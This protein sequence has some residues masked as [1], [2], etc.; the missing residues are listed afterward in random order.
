M[1]RVNDDD[2]EEEEDGMLR[3]IHQGEKSASA[4][5]IP[6]GEKSFP[7]H[8]YSL[9]R[10]RW[11]EDS[12]QTRP[13]GKHIFTYIKGEKEKAFGLD[14]LLHFTC[15]LFFFPASIPESKQSKENPQNYTPSLV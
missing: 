2:D 7:Q 11:R 5:V 1:T 8:L 3:S 15:K 12:P 6:A 10:K 4:V 14:S 13:G 9:A